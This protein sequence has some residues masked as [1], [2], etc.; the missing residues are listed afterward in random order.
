[1][2]RRLAGQPLSALIDA[3]AAG[4]TYVDIPTNDGVAPPT[5]GTGDY[6]GGELRGQIQ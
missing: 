5:T 4:N 6:P 2:L 1:L 3:M